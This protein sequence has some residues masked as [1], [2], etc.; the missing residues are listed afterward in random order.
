MKVASSYFLNQVPLN[1]LAMINDLVSIDKNILILWLAYS[2]LITMAE[3]MDFNVVI[4]YS[5][6]QRLVVAL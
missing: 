4:S 5:L 2:F 6:L 1:K 3:Y